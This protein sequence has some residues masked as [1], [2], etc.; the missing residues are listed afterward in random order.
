MM[1]IAGFRQINDLVESEA[2]F[3]HALIAEIRKTI[4]GQDRLVERT[5][6]GLL[7]DGHI[8]LEAYPVSPRLSWSRRSARR[9]SPGSHESSSH[10]TF[11]LQTS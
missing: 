10:P 2:R 3:V 11:S 6:V 5:L 8:L 9:F 1:D 7:A 4:I